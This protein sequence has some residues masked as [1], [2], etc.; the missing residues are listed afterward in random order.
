[1]MFASL[2]VAGVFAD[3]TA[4]NKAKGWPYGPYDKLHRDPPLIQKNAI[5][6]IFLSPPPARRQILIYRGTQP[7]VVQPTTTNTIVAPKLELAP[8]NAPRNK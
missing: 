1:M 8:M 6:I 2:S 7:E 4:P 5:P 3:G